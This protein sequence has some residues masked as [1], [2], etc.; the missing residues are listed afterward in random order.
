M[1]KFIIF[2]TFDSNIE[3]HIVMGRLLS[4]GV[5]CFLKDEQIVSINPL[6]GVAVG[7]IKLLIRE[8]D[9]DIAIEILEQKPDDV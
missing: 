6:Y 5:P 7:G 9:A 8:Q 3:A 1:S 4:N 2:K